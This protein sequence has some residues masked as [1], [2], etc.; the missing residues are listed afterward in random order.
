MRYVYGW[1]LRPR[2]PLAMNCGVASEES[3]AVDIGVWSAFHQVQPRPSFRRLF[4]RPPPVRDCALFDYRYSRTRW[5]SNDRWPCSACLRPYEA[6]PAYNADI[7]IASTPR[8][9][10]YP[11]Q[12]PSSRTC[13]P[14]SHSSAVACPPTLQR[15]LH[16]RHSSPCPAPNSRNPALSP[17]VLVDIY[18]GGA[19]VS[20]TAS[21]V[22]AAI[23][24]M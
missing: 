11:S 21:S 2:T 17:P 20:G 16:G 15:S 18:Y 1:C 22:L 7:Y 19:T 13:R 10:G 5:R 23:C 24:R 12:H 4:D 3:I 6:R 9:S 14:F 8:P